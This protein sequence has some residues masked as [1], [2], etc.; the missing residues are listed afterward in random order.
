MTVTRYSVGDE[1]TITEANLRTMQYSNRSCVTPNYPTQNFIS[2]AARYIGASGVVTHVFLPSYD[3]TVKFGSE[4]FHM[5]DNWLTKVDKS[6]VSVPIVPENRGV[7]P[8]EGGWKPQTYYAVDVAFCSANVVHRAIF[9]SGHLCRGEPGSG[10]QVW[11]PTYD[12]VE[13]LGT[14]YYLRVIAELGDRKTIG[15]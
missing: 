8:P 5:K 6:Q 14:T 11:N 4:S 10:N 13:E 7:F 2:S 9:Y 1:V 3:V 12:D 15:G